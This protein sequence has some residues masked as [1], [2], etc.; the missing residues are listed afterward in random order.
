MHFQIQRMLHRLTQQALP[1][2]LEVS[3]KLLSTSLVPT[4]AKNDVYEIR[5]QFP[6]VILFYCFPAA[7]VLALEL[8][9]CTIER[10]SLPDPVPR[11]VRNVY[12]RIA[13]ETNT[14]F[15]H[16]RLGSHS[17]PFSSDVMSGLDTAPWRRKPQAL[18]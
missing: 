5:R 10:T 1:A 8:R 18:Q 15:V 11:A 4:K 7:G 2:L 16:A 6:S 14:D 3:L 17:Q 12:V 9:R 13:C